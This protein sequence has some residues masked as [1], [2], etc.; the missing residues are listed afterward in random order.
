MR[1]PVSGEAR[2]TTANMVAL[3]SSDHQIYL[4]IT[5]TLYNSHNALATLNVSS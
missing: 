3:I 1:K 2:K 4:P 5:T